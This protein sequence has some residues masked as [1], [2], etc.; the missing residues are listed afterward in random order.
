ML[1]AAFDPNVEKQHRWLGWLWLAALW[2]IG[3]FLWGKFLNWGQIPFDWLDWA[4]INAPRT[5]FLKDAVMKGVLPLHM[6]DSSALRGVTDRFMSIPDALLSPQIL[7]LRFMEIGTFFLV[8]TLLLYTT[9]MFGL[10]WFRRRFSLSLVSFSALF[11]LFN[12]NGH[13]LAHYSVGHTTWAGYLLFPWFAVLVFRL[14]Q[15]ESSW[16]WVAQTALV[17]FLIYLQGAFHQFIWGL[18]FLG[19]LGLTT[20]ER[21][22]PALKALV[23]ACL[24]SMVR[25]LPPTLLLGQ[26]DDEF[27]GGY[28][29]LMDILDSMVRFK[30]PAEAIGVRTMLSSLAWWEYDLYL[31]LAGTA[32]LAVFGIYSWAKHHRTESGFPALLLPIGGMTLLSVGRVYRLVRLIPIPLL[33]GERASIRMVILPVVFLLILAAIEFQRWLQNRQTSWIVQLSGLGLLLVMGHD[34]WQHAKVWQVTNAVSAFDVARVDLSIKVVANHPD[35]IYFTLLGVGATVTILTLLGL[36][37]LW[38]REGK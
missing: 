15:G 11:L 28:P 20:W 7:L 19:L 5:A 16:R 26:F 12:F 38:R 31:G 34:L 10:L 33:S 9:G 1:A 29:T 27:L 23:S 36:I 14:L 18:M 2:A 30:Y 8:N 25:I 22:W 32:F 21:F 4:E 13:I 3:A 35:P 6:P 24:L 17:L 37:Y